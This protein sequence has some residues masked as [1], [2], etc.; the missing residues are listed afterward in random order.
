[1]SV[2]FGPC[3]FFCLW[4]PPFLTIPCYIGKVFDQI[5]LKVQTLLPCILT[6]YCLKNPLE[7][8][9]IGEHLLCSEIRKNLQCNEETVYSIGK[10]LSDATFKQNVSA[11]A[12]INQFH[13]I[14]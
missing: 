8:A 4:L 5:S 13:R 12:D 2:R 10:G 9:G 14:L 11:D 3:M 6:D 7:C 1:M